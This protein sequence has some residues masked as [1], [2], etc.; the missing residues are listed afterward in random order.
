MLIAAGPERPAGS[1]RIHPQPLD[2][3]DST[4]ALDGAGVLDGAGALDCA[5]AS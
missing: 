4:A 1:T 5:S 3:V 2:A